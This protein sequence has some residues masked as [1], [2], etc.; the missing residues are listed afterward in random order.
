MLSPQL[1]NAAQV[2]MPEQDPTRHAREGSMPGQ[3]GGGAWLAAR[4]A[5]DLQRLAMQHGQRSWR[6]G[7]AFS[8]S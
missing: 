5:L 8:A 6:P 1:K 3:Q 7:I 4:S 2:E